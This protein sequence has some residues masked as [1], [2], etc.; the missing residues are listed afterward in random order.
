MQ[1]IGDTLI[2]PA[3]QA[4][5][6]RLV[7][8]A[9]RDLERIWTELERFDPEYVAIR[10]QKTIKA[11][12]VPNLLDAQVPV[13]VEYYLGD[14][15]QNLALAFIFVANRP[16]VQIVR[17]P[18]NP[19]AVREDLEL[20]REQGD[21]QPIEAFESL[22]QRLH[23]TLIAPLLPWVPEEVGICF[24]PV[25]DLHNI[26]FGALYDGEH[27]LIERNA[28]VVAPTATALRW[29][30]R[31]NTRRPQRCLIVTA[32]RDMTIGREMAI[33]LADFERLA[34]RQIAPLF[35]MSLLV[36]PDQ[37]TKRRLLDE[38][39]DVMD[40]PWDAVHIACH[41][42]FES[43]S[44]DDALPSS[45][46]TARLVMHGTPSDPAKDL[47][48]G[49]IFTFVR[50]SATLVTLSACETAVAQPSTNDEIAGLAQG[51]LF[52]GASS[53]LASQWYVVQGMGV[54]L[55]R[56]FYANW[57]GLRGEPPISKIEALRR[58]QRRL[59]HRKSWFFWRKKRHPYLWSAFQ[60][61]GD[62][63]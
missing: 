60:L 21:A 52:G 3:H 59:M 48:A 22:A 24:V 18:G 11:S 25:G 39:A 2:S 47:T 51:F 36:R 14:H 26:P 58:A 10:R 31:N 23:Q 1:L 33:D 4:A 54:E 17:L 12:E 50:P 35:P 28:I 15:I 42:T 44:A 63:R 34:R 41:A 8:G 16:G 61:L 9:L 30:V 57:I 19:K 37:A 43:Q 27:Y 55:T 29:W 20:L 56:H 40:P 13:L 45:G 6:N 49:E 46:M 53:V 32:T 38:L 7:E 62:W 5:G